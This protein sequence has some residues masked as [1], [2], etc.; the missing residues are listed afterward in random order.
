MRELPDLEQSLAAREQLLGQSIDCAP[1][2]RKA[3]AEELE[4]RERPRELE[5]MVYSVQQPAADYVE[6][7]VEE[8][9]QGLVEALVL[10]LLRSVEKLDLDGLSM[11]RLSRLMMLVTLAERSAAVVTGRG[12]IVLRY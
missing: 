11:M 12:R 5:R 9:T 7:L 3:E 10:P 6:L 1:G 4:S 2:T 8:C